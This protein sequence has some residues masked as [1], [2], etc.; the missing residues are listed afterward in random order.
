[1]LLTL[2]FIHHNLSKRLWL[3]NRDLLRWKVENSQVSRFSI[4][5]LKKTELQPLQSNS[6][7]IKDKWKWQSKSIHMSRNVSKRRDL[8]RCKFEVWRVNWLTCLRVNWNKFSNLSVRLI[9]LIFTE[10]RKQESA[11]VLHSSNMRTL[12]MRK[13]QLRKWMEYSYWRTIPFLFQL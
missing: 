10:T 11:R 6:M 2:S 1:M 3:W 9:T 7:F 8:Q 13:E 4:L 12:R 5:K